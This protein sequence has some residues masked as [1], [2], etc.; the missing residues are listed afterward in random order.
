S[1]CTASPSSI[2]HRWRL[3]P[4]FDLPTAGLLL[5]GKSAQIGENLKCIGNIENICLSPRHPQFGSRLMVGRS[6]V[7]RQSTT[8]RSST[9]QHVESHLGCRG[10]DPVCPSCLR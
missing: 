4:E 3:Y 1:F 9:W 10:G 6:F 5:G 2:T 8:C 7:K